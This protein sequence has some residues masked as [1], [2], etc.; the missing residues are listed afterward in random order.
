MK[1]GRPGWIVT[2]LARS[3]EAGA[4]ADAML[5]HTST[6]GVRFT[7]VG[8]RELA[9]R[10][11]EVDTEYGPLAVKISGGGNEPVKLKP[12]FEVCARIARAHGIP[13]RLVLDAAV[14]A[15]RQLAP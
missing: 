5:L 14:A 8:R 2:A 11:V 6:I 12:E 15:A 13:V 9:R 1:K 10:I 3:A 4:V 7:E